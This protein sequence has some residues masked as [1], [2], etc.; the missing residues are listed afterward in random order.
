MLHLIA[1]GASNAEIAERFSISPRTAETHRTHVHRKLGF[2]TQAE[3]RHY[4]FKRG[5]M[6]EEP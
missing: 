2:K 6:A 5:L 1:Q 4:A 3:I